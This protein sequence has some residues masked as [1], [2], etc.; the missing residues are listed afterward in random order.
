ML[1]QWKGKKQLNSK[2]MN[3]KWNKV[4]MIL[5]ISRNSFW[6]PGPILGKAQAITMLPVIRKT[7]KNCLHFL[8]TPWE[9]DLS[10]G[11]QGNH[12]LESYR[13]NNEIPELLFCVGSKGTGMHKSPPPLHSNGAKIK[14]PRPKLQLGAL[15]NFF[16]WQHRVSTIFI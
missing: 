13:E 6:S 10:A 5:Q 2:I 7:R 14:Y 12:A 4:I 16:S 15:E 8:L 11:R 1:T 9:S 3:A